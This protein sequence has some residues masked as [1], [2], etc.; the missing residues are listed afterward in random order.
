MSD[1]RDIPMLGKSLS[2]QDHEKTSFEQV[3]A[4]A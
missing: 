3:N 2:E 1:A 4:S